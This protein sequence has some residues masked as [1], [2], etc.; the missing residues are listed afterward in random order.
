MQAGRVP[1][2]K[3]C[4]RKAVDIHFGLRMGGWGDV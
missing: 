3:D 4:K 1:R 2:W